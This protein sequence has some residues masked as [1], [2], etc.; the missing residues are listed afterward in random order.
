[1]IFNGYDEEDEDDGGWI[2]LPREC[3]DTLMRSQNGQGVT[4][5]VAEQLEI[6]E[7]GIVDICRED[8]NR[9]LAIQG[10][11]AFTDLQWEQVVTVFPP[12]QGALQE[13]GL[14]SLVAFAAA[15]KVTLSRAAIQALLVRMGSTATVTEFL[16]EEDG[17][18]ETLVVTMTEESL[19]AR[20]TSLGA[21]A[22]NAAEFA[23]LGRETLQITAFE[24]GTRH[25]LK[26]RVILNPEEDAELGPA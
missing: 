5:G 12:P 25:V 17:D 3:L 26:K 11:N 19:N 24:D 1:M 13:V 22:L 20:L 16:N 23:S 4:E 15:P 8:I 7:G 6:S 10:G 14:E 21:M 2:R 9:I 18:E